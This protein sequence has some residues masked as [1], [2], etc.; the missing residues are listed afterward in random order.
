MILD[1]HIPDT[2]TLWL[3]IFSFLLPILGLIAGLIFRKH[4]YIRNYK[5]CMKG[6]LICFALILAAVILFMIFLGIAHL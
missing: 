1:L 3:G 2:G 4:N 6:V 5:M